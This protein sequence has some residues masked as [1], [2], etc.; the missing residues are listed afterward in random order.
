[1]LS[2]SFYSLALLILFSACTDTAVEGEGG[3]VDGTTT[4]ETTSG[5]GEPVDESTI[6]LPTS[7]QNSTSNSESA[8]VAAEDVTFSELTAAFADSTVQ[9]ADTPFLAGTAVLEGVL[10]V[11]TGVSTTEDFNGE[12]EMN[13]DFGAGTIS[14]TAK[15]F[16]LKTTSPS[17]STSQNLDGTLTLEGV[18][19]GA[20]YF[21]TIDGNLADDATDLDVDLSTREAILGEYEG[22]LMTDATVAG[23]IDNESALGAV[24]AIHGGFSD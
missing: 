16:R 13:V 8:S 20:S 3:T 22:S 6:L 9:P 1:M 24:T 5:A 12:I 7:L 18:V 11:Q 14:G 4:A 21:M 19:N 10:S 2:R 15:S 23:T 17:G